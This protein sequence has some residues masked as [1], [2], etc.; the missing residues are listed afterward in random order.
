MAIGV[1][2]TGGGGSRVGEDEGLWGQEFAAKPVFF[3]KTAG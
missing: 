1:C 2:H 3:H